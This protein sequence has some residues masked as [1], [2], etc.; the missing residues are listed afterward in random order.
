M[1]VINLNVL[2][3]RITI[4]ID[5]TVFKVVLNCFI[6]CSMLWTFPSQLGGADRALKLGFHLQ[7]FN[8]HL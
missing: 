7:I 3:E 5:V 8:D 1:S 4:V 2:P 6:L